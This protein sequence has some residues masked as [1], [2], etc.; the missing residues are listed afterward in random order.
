MKVAFACDHAG[1][2]LKQSLIKNLSQQ[3][4]I[5]DCGTNDSTTSVDYPD[6]AHI[7]CE[8]L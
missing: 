1:F 8:L 3:Y 4:Q 5:T 2:E 7:G 6:F